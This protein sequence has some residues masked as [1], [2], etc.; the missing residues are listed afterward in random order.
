MRVG[1]I[2]LGHMGAGMAT[3]LL[4]AGHDLTVWNRTRAKA[5][6]LAGEGAAIAASVAEA[7]RGDAV[8]TMLADDR[9]AESVILGDQGV[10]QSLPPGGLHI[11]ASTVSVALAERL[12]QAHR[13]AGQRFVS[14]P[15]LGR[16][17]VAAKGELFILAGGAPDAVAAAAPLLDAMGK[18]TI[19]FGDRA[20]D[21]NLV[22]LSVNFLIATVFE[23]LGE[24]IGL[25]ER[26]GIDTA[27]YVDFLT[28][29]LFGAPVFKVYGGL[30][31]APEP[32]PMGFAAP[33]G[34]KDIRFALAA[35]KQLG[36]RMPFASLLEQRFETLLE[37]GGEDQDWSAVGRLA[38]A[39]PER[40]A[41]DAE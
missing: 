35:S 1:L 16:P 2:G 9:A 4:R 26:G 38:R 36:A 12:E 21:A 40:E 18:Q 11:S 28:S 10:V 13:D 17:D 39:Q 6:P 22:K 32:P 37:Q 33:L 41:A 7:S 3:S 25:V 29:T 19:P 30:V 23:S 5:E 20:A 24:A 15:V 34:L 8:V 31:A 14:A 27:R